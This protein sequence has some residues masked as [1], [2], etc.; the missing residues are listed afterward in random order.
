M[1]ARSKRSPY[2]S[3]SAADLKHAAAAPSRR[4]HAR[5]THAELHI[6]QS[7]RQISPKVNDTVR[8]PLAA[9]SAR[10]AAA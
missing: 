3:L 8:R 1:P 6:L 9:S 5:K 4:M 2:K 7:D 10:F